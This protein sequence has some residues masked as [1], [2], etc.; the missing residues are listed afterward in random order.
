MLQLKVDHSNE[1]STGDATEDFLMAMAGAVLGGTLGFTAGDGRSGGESG[2]AAGAQ[3]TGA[4]G[5]GADAGPYRIDVAAFHAA[6]RFVR[7]EFG[8]IAYIERGSGPA[9]LFLHGLPLNGFQWRGALE[10]LWPERRCIAPDFMGLGYSEVPEGQSPS[11]EARTRMVAALLDA[12][13]ID[14]VDIVANDSGNTIAQL[15]AAHYPDRLRTLLLTNG[16]VRENSPPPTIEGLI[17][18]SHEGTFV[19]DVLVPQLE[20]PALALEPTGLGGLCYTDP[21]F[22]TPELLEVYTRPLVAPELREA[23]FDRYCIEL[24]PNPLLAIAPEL[25]RSRV[26]LRVV[27]GTGDRFFPTSSAE[28]LDRTFPNSQGVRWVEEAKLFFPE[29]MPNLIADEACRLWAAA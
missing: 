6:R 17:A 18:A 21:A 2:V 13:G 8:R 11:P 5:P 27:W 23:Q 12:L 20:D 19:D 24:D 3:T 4:S 1:R 28:W 16:D 25:E 22:V 15:F 29:E 7:T 10:R 14:A 26:P 9:A